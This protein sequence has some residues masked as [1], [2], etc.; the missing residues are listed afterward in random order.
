VVE[1]L[2]LGADRS[3][4][5][6]ALRVLV[7]WLGWLVA[8]VAGLGCVRGWWWGGDLQNLERLP[9]IGDSVAVAAV[10]RRGWPWVPGLVVVCSA[11]FAR[12]AWLVTAGSVCAAR[13]WA[14]RR[15]AR[16]FLMAR[17]R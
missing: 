17:G 6:E 8:V 13:P 16:R 3:R 9:L 14:R 12:R 2:G 4:R 10:E 5:D 1:P 7:G 15:R 11:V